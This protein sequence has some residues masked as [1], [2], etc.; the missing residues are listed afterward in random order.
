MLIWIMLVLRFLSLLLV[1]LYV[2]FSVL[3]ILVIDVVCWNTGFGLVFGL[4]MIGEF[5]LDRLDRFN[6]L[7]VLDMALAYW[8][9]GLTG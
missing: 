8:F 3:G 4:M 5:L 9:S 7:F 2:C 6:G 1:G